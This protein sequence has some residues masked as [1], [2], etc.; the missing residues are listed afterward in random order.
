[1]ELNDKFS[2]ILSNLLKLL[3]VVYKF[4]RVNI[5][6]EIIL[7]QLNISLALVD[8]SLDYIRE[9]IINFLE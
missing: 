6:I 7:L 8:A 3:F 5:F 9:L 4:Y 2:Y 1:M